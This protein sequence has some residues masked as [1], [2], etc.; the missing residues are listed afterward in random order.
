MSVTTFFNDWCLTIKDQHPEIHQIRM[1][2]RIKELYPNMSEKAITYSVNKI[3]RWIKKCK[4]DLYEITLHAAE[5]S[6]KRCG[7]I[8]TDFKIG[9]NFIYLHAYRD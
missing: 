3:S 4:F 1:R 6:I 7:E 2:K 5:P 8:T 9:N